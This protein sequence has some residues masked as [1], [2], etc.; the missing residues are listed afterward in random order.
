MFL[1]L[2]AKIKSV[3]LVK[4]AD[5]TDNLRLIFC[6]LKLEVMIHTVDR[7]SGVIAYAIRHPERLPRSCL[8]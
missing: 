5:F 3:H 1:G 2:S 7:S 4:F 6:L 8:S